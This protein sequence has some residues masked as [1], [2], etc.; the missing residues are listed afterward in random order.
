M[1]GYI[2]YFD[3]C[4]EPVNPGG[5]MGFGAVVTE[6]GQIIWQ[7][8]GMSA[9]DS[10]PTS[11]NLAEYTALLA[12]LD[13]FIEADLV[14]SEIEIRGDSKLVIEQ[15]T[16]NWRIDEGI[17]VPAARHAERL[18]SKFTNLRLL[19]IPREYNQIADKLSKSELIKADIRIT[20]RRKSA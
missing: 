1:A 9:P 15:M 3:G 7:S 11:N 14:D 2:A 17:Y 6:D 18:A 20:V 12:L 8:C 10:G 4:C 5:T 13:Y 16:G 19:W